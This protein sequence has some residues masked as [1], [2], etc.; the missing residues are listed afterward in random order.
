MKTRN[1]SIY[2]ASI[3]YLSLARIAPAK[4]VIV[5]VTGIVHS[6]QTEGGFALDGSISE[7][8]V[9]TGTCTYD[10]STPDLDDSPCHGTYALLSLSMTI[11]NYTFTHDPTPTPAGGRALF[12][13]SVVDL[14]YEAHSSAPFFDGT[15]YVNGSP[16]TYNDIPWI[17]TYL[18]PIDVC[19]ST[20]DYTDNDELPD[21]FPPISAF[22]WRREFETRFYDKYGRYF[23]ISGEITSLAAAPGPIGVAPDELSF[24]R[25]IGEPSPQPQTLSIRNNTADTLHWQ[26][27]EDCNWLDVCPTS[28]QSSGEVDEVIVSIDTN[29]LPAGRHSCGL[30]ISDPD[31]P[32]YIRYVPVSLLI[33]SKLLVPGQHPNI[34]AA[35]D[36]AG[37]YDTV[38]VAPGTY[39][40]PGNRDIDFRGKPV[41][42]RSE[43]GPGN[44]IIDCNGT[45]YEP[46]SGFLFHSLEDA[47]SVLDGFTITNGCLSGFPGPD[48][49]GGIYCYNSSPTIRNCII[50]G[51]SADWGTGGGIYCYR[52]DP[53]IINCTISGNSAEYDGGGISCEKYSNPT[54]INCIITGNSAGIAGGG[55]SCERGSNLTIANCTLAE[56]YAANGNA[57]AC[58]FYKQQYPSILQLTNCILWDGGNEIWNNDN[59]TID[60]TYSNVQTG[61]PGTG[62]ID[63]D[64]CFVSP[65]CWADSNDPNIIVEPNAPNAIWIEGDYHLYPF[66]LCIN[67][68]DPNYIVTP[69]ETNLDGSP[70][71]IAGRIDMGAYESNHTRAR[72]WIFPR[73]IYRYSHTQRRISAWLR[74][75]KGVTK[76]DIDSNTPL[77]LYPGEIEPTRQYI[78]PRGRRGPK[79]VSIIAY[80]DKRDLMDVISN[81]GRVELK[82]VGRLKTGRYFF[83]CDTARIIHRRHP[84]RRPWR[85]R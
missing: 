22:N 24:R 67:A 82:L 21:S 41:M 29:N 71:I 84:P 17:D 19:S 66:S 3:V 78:F 53:T 42:L 28:G 39:T 7:G 25:C 5:E 56:N 75:P 33:G 55:I 81:N 37:D 79:R 59:S 11:G 80:F 35:I 38:L 73:L 15:I 26:I 50:T 76:D 44:C 60:I 45:E 18:K 2:L 72:L 68:G 20:N 48:S 40:G 70:R 46:H 27:N 69:G 51:N 74:L 54:I 65:G 52:S 1:W 30:I 9:M 13:V 43:N 23:R 34:Q 4:V 61:W 36:A 12:E 85:S 57:L 77:L 14:A 83:G 32:G 62:N 49:G 58:D 64:P 47:D 16:K 10:T 6:V 8:S 31:V 63:V